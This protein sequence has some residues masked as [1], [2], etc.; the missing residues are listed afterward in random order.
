MKFGWK[1]WIAFVPPGAGATREMWTASLELE[2]PVFIQ[3]SSA[4][5]V[6]QMR[7]LSKLIPA[8]ATS[9]PRQPGQEDEGKGKREVVLTVGMFFSHFIRYVLLDY[10]RWY[11]KGF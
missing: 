7:N 2:D 4:Q 6:K 9:L 10:M 1:V 5:D 11:V 8:T 3:I